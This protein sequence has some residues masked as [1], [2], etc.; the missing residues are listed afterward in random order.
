CEGPG[1]AEMS[2]E[3]ILAQ[4]L[5]RVAAP[6]ELWER[7]QS[8]RHNQAPRDQHRFSGEK[9]AWALVAAMLVAVLVWG[10]PSH[11]DLAIRSADAAQI[12]KWV[13]TNAGVD[14]PL[15]ADSSP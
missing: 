9:L 13:K 8:P 3:P 12:R 5:R 14:V 2:I 4:K 6:E 7:I 1:E 10:F 15:L 11:R